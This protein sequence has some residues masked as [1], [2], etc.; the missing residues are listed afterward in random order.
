[1]H[2][3]KNNENPYVMRYAKINS[4]Y[5][6]KEKKRNFL[7]ESQE[8]TTRFIGFYSLFKIHKATIHYGSKIKKETVRKL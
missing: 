2:K 3:K 5:K 8:R 1:M 6:S 7:G 4:R